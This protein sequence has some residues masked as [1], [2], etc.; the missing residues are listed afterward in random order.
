M[1][2]STMNEKKMII[3]ARTVSILFTPFYWPLIGIII[4]FW[5]SSMEMAPLGY[6]LKCIFTV[7]LLSIYLPTL[8]I[9]LYHRYNGWSPFQIGQKEK[10]MVPYIISIICYFG[11][12][13]MLNWFR[14][15]HH[16]SIILILAIMVQIVCAII[17][18]WWKIS[19]HMAALGGVTA[20]IY[21]FSYYF[22]VNIF[23]WFC[24]AIILSG[25]VGTSRLI[26][27]QHS[28]SQVI[29]GYFMGYLLSIGILIYSYISAFI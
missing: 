17:N 16:M 29:T 3:M 14:L 15:P 13:Y 2:I 25:L 26:L 22:N 12:Y 10:R 23:W 6:K 19:T 11:C 27:R 20:M 5:F 8:L 9:R 28:F 4:M 21:F 1:A 24:T 18:V 7:Y